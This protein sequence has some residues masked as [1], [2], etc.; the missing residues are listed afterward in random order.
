MLVYVQVNIL[1]VFGKNNCPIV[2]VLTLAL[3][4]LSV[5]SKTDSTYKF[6]SCANFD[7]EQHKRIEPPKFC[8]VCLN[9][10]VYRP[11]NSV[12]FDPYQQCIQT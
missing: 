1:V 12:S 7:F 4:I 6:N 8:Q 5:F 3:Q 9:L 11:T 2:S 10:T